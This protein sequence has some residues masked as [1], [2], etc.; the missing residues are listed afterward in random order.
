MK[1]FDRTLGRLKVLLLSVFLVAGLVLVPSTKSEAFV[2][3]DIPHSFFLEH[4]YAMNSA[5]V[6]GEWIDLEGSGSLWMNQFR[7]DLDIYQNALGV[8]AKLPFAGVTSFG[9]TREDEYDIGNLAVGAKF[10]MVNMPGTVF[11]LGFETIVPTMSD[12]LGSLGAR[13][14]FRDFAYFVDDAVTLKPYAIVGASSGIFAIQGNLEFDILLNA[15]E[16]EGDSSELIIRYGGTASATPQLN[17]PFTTSF[18]V[19]VLAASS[20]TFSN[21][22]HGVYIT[23]GIRI[24]GDVLSI[25]AGVEIPFGSSEIEDFANVGIVLDLVFRFGA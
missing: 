14:Y 25:G 15:D 8:Y 23:P 22:I 10:V 20:T 21:N 7:V 12:D 19:E 2:G 11:T 9:P 6:R 5:S 13:A 1:I 24:G 18:L 3:A 16:V 17:L 4:P